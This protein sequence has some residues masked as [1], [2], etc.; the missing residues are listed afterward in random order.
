M[1]KKMSLLEII[2]LTIALFYPL[3]GQSYEN[4][5]I[6]SLI[7][8]AL[9]NNPEIR[10]LQKQLS[11]A[12][13][14]I[15]PSGSLPDPMVKLGVMNLPVNSFVF[16]QEPMTGKQIMLTQ[17]I[18]FLGILGSK[19]EI[20][21]QMASM[22]ETQ[23][24]SKK[25]EVVRQIKETVFNLL[26]FKEAIGLAEKNQEILNQFVQVATTKYETGQGLQQDILRAQVALSKMMEK[27]I[28]LRQNESSARVMLNT[29]L[30]RAVNYPVDSLSEF[31]VPDITMTEDSL[32]ALAL[33]NNPMLAMKEAQIALSSA[34][35]NLAS[36]SY[37]PFLEISVSYTQRENVMGNTMHD[38]FSAQASF[39]LPLW[40]WR[41]HKNKVAEAQFTVEASQTDLE[42]T[43]KTI[44]K[45]IADILLMLQEQEKRI[46]IYRD[47]ILPQNEQS[48][49]AAFTAYTVDKIDFITL[50]NNQKMLF[51]DEM[52][53]ARLIADHE[54]TKAKLEEAVGIR[55]F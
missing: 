46:V 7:Q 40:F 17:R 11:A 8:E 34:Q 43:I 29:I 31:T 22:V 21:R 13:A 6:E 1:K 53:Y 23:L 55:I 24:R 54:I 19:T 33:D 15:A 36:R 9:N 10:T 12:R 25:N 39:T 52:A 3:W 48:I 47:G 30:N 51:D 38:F 27:V 44:Q 41:N 20:S 28:M 42:N 16:N 35:K 5:W 37:F 4:D 26:Y 32:R 45:K 49:N 2:G 14:N 50:Q 18:P